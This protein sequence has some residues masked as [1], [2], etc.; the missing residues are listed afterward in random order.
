MRGNRS[1]QAGRAISEL[2]GKMEGGRRVLESL[3][4]AYWPEIVGPQ[5]A[6]ATEAE[7][8]RDGVLQ[9]RTRSSAWSQELSF[10]R[11]ALVARLNER[12]GRPVIKGVRFSA[13]GAA[14]AEPPPEPIQPV[15][16][17]LDRVDLPPHLALELQHQTRAAQN[18]P[19]ERLRESVIRAMSRDARAR[20]WRLQNGWRECPRCG[21]PYRAPGEIC[22]IC[23]RSR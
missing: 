7:L 4:V 19:N 20:W 16:D 22:P 13:R 9:V 14:P 6:A 18:I 23:A 21:G 8:V 2:L 15:G 17:E 5:A 12:I 10:H 1:V 11:E 3:A